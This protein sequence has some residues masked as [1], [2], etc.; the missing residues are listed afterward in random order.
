MS[1]DNAPVQDESQKKN[2]PVII[3]IVAALAVVIIILLVLLVI[4][5][6]ANDSA[7]PSASATPAATADP[8]DATPGSTPSATPPSKPAPSVKPE[9]PNG[10][11]TSSSGLGGLEPTLAACGTTEL[12]KLTASGILNLSDGQRFACIEI[13]TPSLTRV[14]LESWHSGTEASPDLVFALSTWLPDGTLKHVVTVDDTFGSDPEVNMALLG[15][16]YLIEV[17]A[18]GQPS[19]DYQLYANVDKSMIRTGAA[20]PQAS[21]YSIEVCSDDAVLFV[22]DPGSIH[23]GASITNPYICINVDALSWLTIFAE[24]DGGA[25][26]LT[27]EVLG[28][29][30]NGDAERYYFNDDALGQAGSGDP[31]IEGAFPPGDYIIFIDEFLLGTPEN[32][33]VTV[34][35]AD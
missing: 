8:G 3:A 33:T 11:L 4:R 19:G 29:D 23:V 30:Q 12:P 17:D 35:V 34:L 1:A 9:P 15:G 16:T 7:S 27:M 6:A 18:F 21:G 25:E 2:S 10:D 13:S 5:P 14:G 24:S 32:F 26:D 28:F 20:S 31:L 22:A